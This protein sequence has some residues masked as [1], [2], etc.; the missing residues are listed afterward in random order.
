MRYAN[1]SNSWTMETW[2]LKN[3]L[4]KYLVE[5]KGFRELILE[6]ADPELR[7][8]NSYLS[9]SSVN[10]VIILDSIFNNTFSNNGVRSSL[11]NTDFKDLMSWI[12]GYNMNHQKEI[13]SFRGMDIFVGWGTFW[14]GWMNEMSKKRVRDVYGRRDLTVDETRDIVNNWYK[15]EK[16]KLKDSLHENSYRLLEMDIK[17]YMA[18]F[19]YVKN[20]GNKSIHMIRMRDSLMAINVK[21]LVNKKAIIS[22]H[23]L[24]ISNS[25]FHSAQ[26]DAKML[27][28]Y[29]RDRYGDK[30][31]ILLTDFSVEA[32]VSIYSEP[33]NF[34]VR[35]FG[36]NPKTLAY[37]LNKKFQVAEGLVFDKDLQNIVD[38]KLNSIGLKGDRTLNSAPPKS[39]DAL[40]YFKNLSPSIMLK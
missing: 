31:Y 16:Q 12:K 1:I 3:I 25:G 14:N 6:Y 38:I 10:N 7:K 13:I 5:K 36:S 35:K 19:D 39:F 32:N 33:N 18:H 27:G 30:Y 24:H 17:N 15:L 11:Y 29:L 2:R 9:D 21:Q 22:A 8:L 20:G 37:T 4:I 34:M 40:I 26:W 23:N 28:N